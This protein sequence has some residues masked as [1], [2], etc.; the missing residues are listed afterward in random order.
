MRPDPISGGFQAISLGEVLSDV[1][2]R[3]EVPE[4]IRFHL[5]VLLQ[6]PRGINLR[7]DFAHGLAAFDLFDRGIANWV[8]HAVIMLGLIRLR[9]EP[10]QQPQQ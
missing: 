9:V 4:D 3:S 1:R 6:D 7:N 5:R 2:F 10:A 8:V